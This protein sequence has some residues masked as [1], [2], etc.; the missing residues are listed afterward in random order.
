[1][2]CPKGVDIPSNFFY[3][4]LMYV[5]GKMA[6]RVKF[7]QNAGIQ[8]NPGFASLCIGCGKCESHCPQHINIRE[9]L[10]E[11][12]K[13]LRPLPFKA[14]MAIARKFMLRKKSS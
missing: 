6:A 9:K 12:D 14:G 2:P 8:K 10:K 1:M 3:Y 5:D 4:N 11:A 7:A 13:N